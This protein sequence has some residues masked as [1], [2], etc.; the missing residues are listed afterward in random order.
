MTITR[1]NYLGVDGGWIIADA[2]IMETDGRDEE[3]ALRVVLIV[4]GEL[5]VH[6]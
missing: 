4:K 2:P 6:A 1:G 5:P 3:H